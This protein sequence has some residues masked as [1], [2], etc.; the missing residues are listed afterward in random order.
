MQYRLEWLETAR[1]DMIDAVRYISSI[2]NN[3]KAADSLSE[4]FIKE[5][6]K[7]R[8]FPKSFRKYTPIKPL[9]HEYRRIQVDNFQMYFWINEADRIV[10]ISRVL[11]K[12]QNIEIF[13][14]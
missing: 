1:Q 7:A 2:L 12:K 10:I 4:K 9:K 14:E 6:E 3:P 13:L 11:Y 5:A 8:N